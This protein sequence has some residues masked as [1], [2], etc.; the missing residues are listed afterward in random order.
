METD[1]AAATSTRRPGTMAL[2]PGG[3]RRPGI[4]LARRQRG[5][6]PRIERAARRPGGDGRCAIVRRARAPLRRQRLRR[7]FRLPPPPPSRGRSGRRDRRQETAGGRR[8]ARRGRTGWRTSGQ[9][10][11]ALRGLMGDP[12]RAA[13]TVLRALRRPGVSSRRLGE[14]LRSEPLRPALAIEAIVAAARARFD[15]T[16]EAASALF[17]PALSDWRDAVGCSDPLLVPGNA[18]GETA[19]KHLLPLPLPSWCAHLVDAGVLYLAGSPRLEGPRVVQRAVLLAVR[20][21]E[22]SAVECF[23]IVFAGRFGAGAASPDVHLAISPPFLA[24]QWRGSVCLRA[25]AHRAGGSAVRIS[26]GPPATPGTPPAGASG[27]TVATWGVQPGDRLP[28][29]GAPWPARWPRWAVLRLLE[30]RE[31]QA[32]WDLSMVWQAKV[33]ALPESSPG[34]PAASAA[35]CRLRVA[36]DIGSTST[37]VVEEDSAAAGSVGTK[38]LGTPSRRPVPS[39]FRL[40]AGDPRTAHR[41]GC[42]ERLLAPGGQVPTAIAAASVDALG[43]LLRD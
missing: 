41:Y 4:D 37:V 32:L 26:L 42:A 43:D 17:A 23:P 36:V 9:G 5:R 8:A 2:A 14:A 19:E 1:E 20:E 10:V 6:A 30:G 15:L 35:A 25:A 22:L 38:L 40:L 13:G 39:G 12:R 28:S 33:G 31:P 27:E 11:P 16:E 34:G 29:E 18:Q 24:E 21:A 3:P 7:A